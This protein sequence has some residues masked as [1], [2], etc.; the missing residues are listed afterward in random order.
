LRPVARAPPA[1]K[2]TLRRREA[3]FSFDHLIAPPSSESG[4]LTPRTWR[5]PLTAEL[6]STAILVPRSAS[7]PHSGPSRGDPCRSAIRPT[8]TSA[9]RPAMSAS[10]R[11]AT[12]PRRLKC[13]NT[14]HVWTARA[15]RTA[16]HKRLVL[17]EHWTLWGS[18]S[19]NLVVSTIARAHRFLQSRAFLKPICPNYHEQPSPLQSRRAPPVSSSAAATS[20]S[21]PCTW[22]SA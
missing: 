2:P 5:L 11:F 1:A 18:G 8:A 14:G 21:V 19:R 15:A 22:Y 9:R 17:A 7:G 3:P 6:C 20:A 4:T 13:A 16:G 10:R 12:S